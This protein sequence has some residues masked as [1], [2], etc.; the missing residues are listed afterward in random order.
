MNTKPLKWG[1]SEYLKMSVA[2]MGGV[3]IG[4]GLAM[5][6]QEKGMMIPKV[7]I[8]VGLVLLIIGVI[9]IGIVSRRSV[10]SN[11]KDRLASVYRGQRGTVH[12]IPVWILLFVV[13]LGVLT[14]IGLWIW[15]SVQTYETVDKWVADYQTLI[16]GFAGALVMFLG[17]LIA[18]GE[19]GSMGRTRCAELLLRI[20]EI[21]NSDP[22]VESRYLI[23]QEVTQAGSEEGGKARLSRK[24]KESDSKGEKDYFI[25]T[26]APNLLETLAFLVEEKYLPV[27]QARDLFGQPMKSYYEKVSTYIEE[28]QK[29]R[30]KEET[31]KLMKT[32]AGRL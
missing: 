10:N 29:I 4:I 31:Y 19:L 27:R 15:R 13:I 21:W 11:M 25:L 30:G 3:F 32:V 24:L 7:P 20:N 17:V 23:D 16:V 22:Y 12:L 14:Y 1:M 2:V 9:L 18:W 8:P 5:L 6:Y 28:M 26:R